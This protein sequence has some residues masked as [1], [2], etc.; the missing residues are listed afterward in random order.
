MQAFTSIKFTNPTQKEFVKTLRNRVDSYFKENGIRKTGGLKI[1]I[2][3]IF[4]LSLYTVPYFLMLFGVITNPW[5]LLSMSILMGLGMAGIGLSVMH[6]ANHGSFSRKKW[7]NKFV[8]F[9]INFLGGNVNNWKAQHNIM[10]HSYTNIHGYDEDIETANILRFSPHSKKR[11]FHKF[12]FLYAWPLYCLM[13]LSWT[14]AKDFSDVYNYKKKG[15]LK[16]LKTTLKKEMALIIIT[17]AIYFTY[18]IVVPLLVMEISWWQLSIGFLIIHFVA[19][20]TLTLIFQLAHIMEETSFPTPVEGGIKNQWAV[21]QLETTL[22]FANKNRPLSWFIGGLN[23]QIEHHLFP[24]I[25]H[26]H[27]RRIAPIIEA[28]AREFNLPYFK[29]DTFRSAVAS[30]AR[31]LYQLGRN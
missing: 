8:G 10:H 24:N 28:T 4:M 15:L 2:K 20:L 13:T 21:H 27:Y 23:F 26:I 16:Q 18:M 5:I 11:W 12:Q 30:H 22:N 3:A 9:S 31:L 14:F 6:D 25:C 19:G 7:L 1:K 29:Q 17:R